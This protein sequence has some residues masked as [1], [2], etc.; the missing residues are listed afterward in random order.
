MTEEQLA[1]TL[2]AAV[3]PQRLW[4]ELDVRRR[5]HR[6]PW[7]LVAVQADLS[8]AQLERLRHGANSRIVRERA[9]A[10]LERKP[11]PPRTE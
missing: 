11:A 1:A 7:W 8:Q 2:A 10:W 4:A 9:T 3:T 6:M 5:D